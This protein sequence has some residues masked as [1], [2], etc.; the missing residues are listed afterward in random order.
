VGDIPK[1]SFK[2]CPVCIQA[3]SKRK[4][5][6]KSTANPPM[7]A[8]HPMDVW[9]ADLI[10]PFTKVLPNGERVR[11]STPGG[12]SYCVLI[13]DHASRYCMAE[14][15]HKK[16][17][18]TEVVIKFIRQK[19]TLLGKKLKR[20]HCDGGGEF[21]NKRFESF[22]SEEGIEL[23]NTCADTSEHNGISESMNQK[24][25]I[26]SRSFIIQSKGPTE[27][28]G[29]AILHAVTLHNHSA[30]KVL[31][32][33][34]PIVVFHESNVDDI[35][36]F[37]AFQFKELKLFGC[38]AFVNIPESRRGKFDSRAADGIYIG[39]SRRYN[40][41][42]ILM[43]NTLTERMERNVTFREKSFENVQRVYSDLEK[44]SERLLG[45]VST[46]ETQWEVERL[47]NDT[48]LHG[49]VNYLVK[50]K[51]FQHP[52]WQSEKTLMEDCP[53]IVNSYK[54][55]KQSVTT[56][57]ANVS[58][59][60]YPIPITYKD[61][62][63]HPDREKWI[64]AMGKEFQSLHDNNTWEPSD[65]P[66]GR[67]PLSTRWVYT[68][69]HDEHNEIQ[70][71]KARLVV[72]GFMQREGIDFNETFAPTVGIKTI[73][74]MF[75]MA[76]ELDL[77]IMQIDFDTAFLYAS[78]DEE[79]YIKHP[80]GYT[81]PPGCNTLPALRLLKSLYGLKQAPRE[82][83]STVRKALEELGYSIS[84]LDEC[85][86]M[87]ILPD[88]R[89]IYITVYV[90]DL[91]IF[92]PK[93]V[94]SVWN[95]DK[96]K[97]VSQF[98]IK[99]IGQCEWILNMRVT[100]DRQAGTIVLSQ[101]NYIDLLLSD[102]PPSSDRLVMSPYKWKDMTIESEG[103]D[104]TPLNAKDHSQY[105]SIVG[106]L[107][108]ISVVTRP[109]LSHVVGLL[110]RY[111]SAPKQYHL[112]AADRVLQYLSH[113]RSECLIFRRNTQWKTIEKFLDFAVWTDSDF[114]DG[115][116]DRKSIT[117][118]I[119]TLNDCPITWKSKK[120]STTALSAG[121]AECYALTEGIREALFLK[122][123]LEHYF[124]IKQSIVV[125]GDNTGSHHF[126]DHP[127]DHEKTK[128]YD[129]KSL[130]NREHVKNKTVLLSHVPS[131]ENIADIFTK[132]TT[133]KRF[134]YLKVK[135]LT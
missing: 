41:H 47:V 19:Q 32:N 90:D 117:G 104:D 4:N 108:W 50:W 1:D 99:D 34:N 69:K 118:Y 63:S 14:L 17:D 40:A 20:F 37:S 68:V 133:P 36:S 134:Q 38:D 80:H 45:G 3:N 130:F 65:L 42:R 92:Y 91:L 98:K 31:N 126:A 96:G 12:H 102:Y 74:Y 110:S 81:A 100:R 16:S 75:A 59:I 94:E 5:I 76:A 82:W 6:K 122:Q 79:I 131:M 89:R 120:Q 105:R 13:T 124:D 127:T 70:R 46:D 87:K 24:M 57:S 15:L 67:K 103:M 35:K 73:K 48:K 61:A 21:N 23:T 39:Y 18:A 111:V 58:V 43:C 135:L 26:I 128:H 52:T 88:G 109:D 125:N 2:D 66:K 28:W 33:K 85:L 119:V 60:D 72:K 77:E 7:M 114:A 121:E 83:Y 115:R 10:G 44:R 25:E 27:L 101:E 106:Q 53:D 97:L 123:W 129:V 84:P 11:L 55:E 116:C 51:G 113:H 56:Q 29:Y 8:I 95:T 49:K 62:M 107:L 132:S 30:V 22:L 78:L 9:S 86:I 93:S 112:D 54:T 64:E 71:W